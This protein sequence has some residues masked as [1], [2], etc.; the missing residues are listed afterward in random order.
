MA[1]GS[2]GPYGRGGRVGYHG[3]RHR[4]PQPEASGPSPPPE[5]TALPVAGSTPAGTGDTPE[6]T[7][8]RTAP[9]PA[10]TRTPEAQPTSGASA[11]GRGAPRSHHNQSRQGHPARPEPESTLHVHEF[12][13]ARVAAFS[14][15]E[16]AIISGAT[17]A[18]IGAI[19]ALGKLYT[20]SARNRPESKRTWSHILISAQPLK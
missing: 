7:D 14:P 18:G 4:R 8:R 10:P 2:G 9:E 1:Y 20:I 15:P 5:H 11:L 16:A 13:R 3:R 19:D 6:G 17:Q 12:F